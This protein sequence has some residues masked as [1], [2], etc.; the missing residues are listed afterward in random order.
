MIACDG[1]IVLNE[2]GSWASIDAFSATYRF[3]LILKSMR[4]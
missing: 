2:L 1:F 4:P 3:G